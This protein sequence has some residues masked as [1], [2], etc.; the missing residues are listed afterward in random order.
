MEPMVLADQEEQEHHIQEELGGGGQVGSV[1]LKATNGSNNGGM[2]GNAITQRRGYDHSILASGGDAGNTGGLGNI[3][4]SNSLN[5]ISDVESKGKNGTGGLLIIYSRK[6][7]N[8]G[9]I[10]SNGSDGGYGKDNDHSTSGGSSGG[11]SINIFF[12]ICNIKGNIKAVG[13]NAIKN[14]TN[15]DKT[16]MYSGAGGNGSISNGFI[17]SDDYFSMKN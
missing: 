8:N 1:S 10:E 9:T 15:Y 4:Q 3:I 12:L 2:G 14:Y 16:T 17:L 6:F 11:G 7:V 5:G 13:G